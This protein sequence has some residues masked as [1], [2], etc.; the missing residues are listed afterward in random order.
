MY[1]FTTQSTALPSI[2][3]SGSPYLFTKDTAITDLVPTNTGGAA[4]SWSITSGSLPSGLA[5][6]TSTGVISGTPD[7]VTS[8]N[9]ITIEATNSA[10]SDSATISISVQDLAPSISYSGSPYLFTKDTAITDLVPTNT[11]GAANSWSITS[12]SLPSGLAFSTST[13]VISGTPD[14]VTSFNNN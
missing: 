4:N 2:S 9:S 3:Y 12:G 14:S 10:G 5:F 1:D 7:S 8:S 6:S 11:G 13:G